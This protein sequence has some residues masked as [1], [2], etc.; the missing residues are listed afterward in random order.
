M[1]LPLKIYISKVLQL[2]LQHLTF[3]FSL[4]LLINIHSRKIFWLDNNPSLGKIRYSQL[5]GSYPRRGGVWQSAPVLWQA[6]HLGLRSQ[7]TL[8]T[9][10]HELYFTQMEGNGGTVMAVDYRL[11]RIRVAVRCWGL[12]QGLAVSDSKLYMSN[13]SAVC[14]NR[15]GI[16][17]SNFTNDIFVSSYL[18]R[19]VSG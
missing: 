14:W 7:L 13:S 16:F 10:A 15:D 12:G 19:N 17:K 1:I 11:K 5:D 18:Y 3:C 9:T 4:R 6:G 2:F 8:D